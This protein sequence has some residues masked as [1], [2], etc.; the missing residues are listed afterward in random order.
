MHEQMCMAM[1]TGDYIVEVRTHNYSNPGSLLANGRCCDSPLTPCTFHGCDNHFYYC[2][3]SLG[4]T[5]AGCSGG[6][7]SNININDAPLNFSQDRVLGL[8]N[9]L[10]LPGLTR[11]WHVS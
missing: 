7:S 4:S 2:L 6:K 8:P 10:P 9:P 5:G 1:A 11:E 3:R